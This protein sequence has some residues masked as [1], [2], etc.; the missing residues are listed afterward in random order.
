LKNSES[1]PWRKSSFCESGACVEVAVAGEDIV[2][3]NSKDP[4]G[5][6]L[7]FPKPVWASFLEAVSTGD[8]HVQQPGRGAID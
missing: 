4:Y 5:T 1:L 3:R 7:R 6:T 2:V 8:F